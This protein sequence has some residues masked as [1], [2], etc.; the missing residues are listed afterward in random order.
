M[1]AMSFVDGRFE[2]VDE[3][4]GEAPSFVESISVS[5]DVEDSVDDADAVDD[6]VVA[7][8]D[9]DINVAAVSAGPKGD[10]EVVVEVVG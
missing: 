10:L 9:E 8:S 3:R 7:D 4:V 5:S 2:V 6:A 1:K